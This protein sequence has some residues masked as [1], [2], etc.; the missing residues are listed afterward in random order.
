MNR[1]VHRLL[2]SLTISLCSVALLAPPA[3]AEGGADNVVLA[4][5]TV[6]GSTVARDRAQIAYDP[7]DTVANENVA[8]ARGTDCTGCR[9]VAVAMQI[10]VVESSPSDF[11]PHN[12]AA[13]TNGGCDQCTTYAFAF[14]HVIQ[15]GHV[16]YL[17]AD[18]QQRL[19]ELRRE[20]DAI[21]ASPASYDEMKLQLEDVF[22]RMV[23]T[24]VDD[25]HAAGAP[26]TADEDALAA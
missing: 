20:V 13:A 11:E 9:T 17:S 2:I 25:L 5:N 16:V 22:G 1:S 18:G 8:S 15:P 14:Q 19:A 3:S 10:V 24:V 6:D 21:A 4:T 23:Q 7:G 12:A 26:Q